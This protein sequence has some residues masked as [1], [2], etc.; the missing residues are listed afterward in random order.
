MMR[1]CRRCLCRR[2]LLHGS[3]LEEEQV[4]RRGF[5]SF[6]QLLAADS[7]VAKAEQI[8]RGG[9]LEPILGV[10]G[11]SQLLGACIGAILCENAQCLKG[12][13]DSEERASEQT[14][15]SKRRDLPG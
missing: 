1:C 15:L 5:E 9:E 2:V 8:G 10:Y 7:L 13:T 3:Q 11:G 12:T 6:G 4:K 14:W